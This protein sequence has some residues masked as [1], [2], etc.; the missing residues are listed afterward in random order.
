VNLRYPAGATRLDPNETAGL[1]LTAIATQG[2]LDAFE[3]ANIAQAERWALKTGRR[4]PAVDL[5]TD[6]YIRRLH[7]RMFGQVWR[8][9]GT[10]RQTDKNIGRTWTQIPAQIR[11]LCDD[12]RHWIDNQTYPWDE[13]GARFHHRL[14]F[15]HPFPNGN[16]RHARLM[17]DV[18]L[19]TCGQP[20]FTWGSR[21]NA[22]SADLRE[23]YLVALRAADARD[24]APLLAFVRS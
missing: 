21:S 17:T 11:N 10:Y 8:W 16:G 14:V 13:L 1:R 24:H 15:I 6:A 5:L 4:R 3:Q 9:A 19:H 12:V 18:L 20:L 2:E 22:A 23:R 7:Q